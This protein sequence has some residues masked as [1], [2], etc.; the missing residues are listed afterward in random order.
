MKRHNI[1]PFLMAATLLLFAFPAC[2]GCPDEAKRDG[3]FVHISH[4]AEHPHRFLM[5]L[6]MAT[7]MADGGQDVL[8]YCDIDAV[9]A[10]TADAAPISM[11]EFL[12]SDE[13]LTKLKDAGVTVMACPTCMKV[14]GIEAGD[15]K[16]GVT[17]AQKD[18]F[19]SFTKGR[20]LTIDY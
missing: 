13:L 7:R 15:L 3:V 18:L 12:S 11:E 20:I 9:K 2:D 5:G 1:L 8:V 19:F 14:A 6:T 16:E 4:G 10:L 17:V